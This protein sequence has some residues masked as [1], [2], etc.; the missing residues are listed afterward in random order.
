[1]AHC[2]E[3]ASGRTDG[4]VYIFIHCAGITSSVIA[5]EGMI[6]RQCAYVIFRQLFY[7]VFFSLCLSIWSGVNL[8]YFKCKQTVHTQHFNF[9]NYWAWICRKKL[10]VIFF[11]AQI[12][13]SHQIK[14]K[15][16]DDRASVWTAVSLFTTSEQCLWSKYLKLRRF[17]Q[18]INIGY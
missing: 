10:C 15:M 8:I 7:F 3:W 17:N 6:S 13:N 14:I 18:C 12:T 16:R 2:T 1:M 9:N 5:V 4:K 11:A